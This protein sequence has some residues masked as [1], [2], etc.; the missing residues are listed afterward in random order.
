MDEL[1]YDVND[2]DIN[3]EDL[4]CVHNL[5]IDDGYDDGIFPKLDFMIDIDDE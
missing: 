1:N 4:E 2:E 3:L 5:D